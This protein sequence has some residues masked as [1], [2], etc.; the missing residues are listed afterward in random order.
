[1]R[2]EKRPAKKAKNGF[3]YRVKIEYI[4]EYGSKKTYSKS[5][6]ATKK[7]ARAHGVEI[8]HELKDGPLKEKCDKTFADCFA[9]V[10]ELKRDHWS[11]NTITLY[12]RVFKKHILPDRIAKMPIR[13][14]NYTL[15]QKYFNG[16]S[17]SRR[18]IVQAQ[19]T[20]F[21]H[22][23]RHA[24]KSQYITDNPMHDIDLLFEQKEKETHILSY[25]DLENVIDYFLQMRA[26]PMRKYSYCIAT[27]CGYYLGLRLTEILALEK[28]DFDFDTRTVLISKKLQAGDLKKE[29]MYLTEIMKTAA[30]RASLPIPEPLE[31]ILKSWIA[32][33]PYDL[34]C[35][36]GDGDVIHPSSYGRACKVAG[37]AIGFPFHPHCL[38]H[39]YITNVIKSGC[40]VKTAS[41]LARHSNVQT[42]LGVY[43]HTDDDAKKK[44]IETVFGEKRTNFDPNPRSLN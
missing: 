27:Y 5:G 35:C 41:T 31:K 42:T 3:T 29:K 21:L 34:I 37:E 30:S 13:Q 6:F 26:N 28:D 39:T 32:F 40:D 4:D 25:D 14:I 18:S 23:F 11:I 44:A 38:R 33:N 17:S 9:E 1:M 16:Q 10:K 7:E 36:D 22:V 15:I 24:L 12:D 20:I 8:E 43:A 19:K 2:I